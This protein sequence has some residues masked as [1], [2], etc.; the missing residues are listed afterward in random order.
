MQVLDRLIGLEEQM[1]IKL[2]NRGDQLRK[3][4]ICAEKV[5]NYI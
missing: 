3:S 2:Y 1:G 5:K 4:L